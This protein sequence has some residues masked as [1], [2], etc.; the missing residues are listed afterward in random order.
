VVP[1]LPRPGGGVKI[2]ILIDGIAR[3]GAERQALNAV[4]ALARLGHD[5]ALFHYSDPRTYDAI[6]EH[7]AIASG[8]VRHVARRGSVAFVWALARLLRRERF[9]VLHGFKEL[10]SIYAGL[11]GRLARVPVVVGGARAGVYEYTGGIVR[12][13]RLTRGLLQGWIVNSEAVADSLCRHVGVVRERCHVVPNGVDCAA[14]RST[15]EPDEARLRLGLPAGCPTVTC[16]AAF[17]PEKNHLLLIDAASRFLERVPSAR[18]LLAGDGPERGG[19]ERQVAMM[20]IASRV[21]FLG[22][23]VDVADVFAA[24]SVSVL[25]S[26]YEGLS[27]AAI[28]SMCAGVPVVTTDYPGAGTLVSDGRSGYIVPQ[29]DAASL[30]DRLERLL[31]DPRQRDRMGCEGREATAG[32]FGLEPMARGLV[33][34]YAACGAAP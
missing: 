8:R 12:V 21:K 15:L 9:D 25:T 22:N 23:R 10:P 29:G 13:Q 11:A 6:G 28:E 32:R 34:V 33:S 26:R 3:G 16:L 1:A 18:L 19:L 14:F 20:N 27:N 7:P 2:A 17:R 24:T 30:A 4:E 5:A 31:I